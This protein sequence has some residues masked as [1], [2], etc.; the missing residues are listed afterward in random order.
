[1]FYR[2]TV[3][4]YEAYS[5]FSA[6]NFGRKQDFLRCAGLLAWLLVERSANLFE[7]KKTKSE[8][9]GLDFGYI[10]LGESLGA[11]QPKGVD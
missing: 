6:R 5:T 10:A 11:P 8:I 2:K 3:L 7:I 4:W 9:Q 1:M